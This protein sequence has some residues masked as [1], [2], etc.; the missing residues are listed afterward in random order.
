MFAPCNSS[1]STM[2]L[3]FSLVTFAPNASKPFKCKSTGL[4]PIEHPPGKYITAFLYLPNRAP[5]K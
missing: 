2:Y 3:F 5:I 1:A 4:A